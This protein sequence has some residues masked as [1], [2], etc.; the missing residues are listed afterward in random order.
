MKNADM[1]AMPI[2]QEPFPVGAVSTSYG[3]LMSGLTKREDLAEKLLVAMI[4][5]PEITQY[6]DIF[7]TAKVREA[8]IAI[9][10]SFLEEL[11]K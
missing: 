4:S 1:P 6:E 2:T 3:R 11:E 8:A 5:N 9:A 7:S 10:D